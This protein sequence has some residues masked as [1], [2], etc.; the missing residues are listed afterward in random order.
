MSAYIIVLGVAVKI[1]DVTFSIV[2]PE[3]LSWASSDEQ[4]RRER[5]IG[6]PG[7]SEKFRTTPV[8]EMVGLVYQYLQARKKNDFDN[9]S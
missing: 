7:H 1:A 3:R 4:C 2:C 5:V 9:F 6:F 8:V